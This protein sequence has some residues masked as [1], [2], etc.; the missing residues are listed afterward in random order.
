MVQTNRFY[1][2]RGV[3]ICNAISNATKQ[4]IELRT[5]AYKAT[6]VET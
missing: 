3:K 5:L 2:V 1:H 6:K 4:M